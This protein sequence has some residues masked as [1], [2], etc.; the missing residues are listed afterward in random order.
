MGYDETSQHHRRG[1]TGEK[2]KMKIK[3]LAEMQED[4]DVL[5]IIEILLEGADEE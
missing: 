1:F 4:K 3:T 5:K 2:R